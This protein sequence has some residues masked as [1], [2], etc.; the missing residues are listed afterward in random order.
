MSVCVWVLRCLV[1]LC[2]LRCGCVSAV[3]VGLFFG[4]SVCFFFSLIG[5]WLGGE[6]RFCV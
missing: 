6:R 1:V 3:L 2:E 5:F 4:L